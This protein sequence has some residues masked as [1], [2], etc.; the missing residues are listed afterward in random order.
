[1][2]SWSSWWCFIVEGPVIARPPGSDTAMWLGSSGRDSHTACGSAWSI[3]RGCTPGTPGNAARLS[4]SRGLLVG[5]IMS[6]FDDAPDHE[7]EGFRRDDF[8]VFETRS[9]AGTNAETRPL[10]SRSPP[11]HAGCMHVYTLKLLSTKT[12]VAFATTFAR[13]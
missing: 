7:I 10:V 12:K 1:M 13:G 6:D 4:S 5:L 9:R 2:R 11:V 8:E 3:R